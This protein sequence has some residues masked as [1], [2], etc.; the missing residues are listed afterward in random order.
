MIPLLTK[1]FAHNI[2]LNAVNTARTPVK[3]YRCAATSERVWRHQG[4]VLWRQSFRQRD[5][6]CHFDLKEPKDRLSYHT[7]RT[8]SVLCGCYCQELFSWE[9]GVQVHWQPT[10]AKSWTNGVWSHACIWADAT[11]HSNNISWWQLKS[12]RDKFNTDSLEDSV[13]SPS[14]LRC[15][16]GQER[17][18]KVGVVFFLP[19]RK[20]TYHSNT[21]AWNKKSSLCTSQIFVSF[22]RTFTQLIQLNFVPSSPFWHSEYTG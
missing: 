14:S 10:A 7:R 1:L 19:L 12:P 11:W 6:Q 15:A 17:F 21:C 13:L 4:L 3:W 9:G 18:S 20:R 16:H 2:Y 22:C 8:D 5:F